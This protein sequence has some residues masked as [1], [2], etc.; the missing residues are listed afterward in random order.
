[1]SSTLAQGSI[2]WASIPD[3]RGGNEKSRPAVIVTATKMIQPAG[4]I[5][6]AA[7]T[8]LIGQA[9]FSETVELPFSSTGHPVTKLKKP[10][11][12]VCSWIVSVPVVNIIDSGGLV[13][14]DVLAEII[15]K[16]KRLT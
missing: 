2:V 12:V 10:C 11:E 4:Q 7:I 1:M 5:E 6:I 9:P 13:P 15:A 3:P 14:A 8:T 16:V